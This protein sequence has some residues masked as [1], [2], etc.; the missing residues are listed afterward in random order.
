M[1]DLRRH[2]PGGESEGLCNLSGSLP[3][4]LELTREISC[5]GVQHGLEEGSVLPG[6]LAHHDQGAGT[7]K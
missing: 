2:C 3:T 4:C 5:H 7:I 6:V 1:M